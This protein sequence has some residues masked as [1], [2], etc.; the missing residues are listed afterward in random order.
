MTS[1]FIFAELWLWTFVVTFLVGSAWAETNGD[2]IMAWKLEIAMIIAMVIAIIVLPALAF[3]IWLENLGN[4][5]A[6]SILI[7]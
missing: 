3:R 4:P 6:V 2:K 5:F 7:F 1:A